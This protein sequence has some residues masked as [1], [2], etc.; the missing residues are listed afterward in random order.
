[1]YIFALFRRRKYIINSSSYTLPH[2]G[3]E[4]GNYILRDAVTLV[5]S[6]VRAWLCLLA[7]LEND[8][9]ATSP[10]RQRE[11]R[12]RGGRALALSL[13]LS[14][15]SLLY[16]YLTHTGAGPLEYTLRAARRIYCRIQ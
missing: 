15:Y 8:R 12:A 6:S 4:R 1:M 10:L 16:F 13:S 3:G 5:K 7:K 2:W 14:L 11:F 9:R